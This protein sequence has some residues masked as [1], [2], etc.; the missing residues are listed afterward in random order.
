MQ[1]FLGNPESS[2]LSVEAHCHCLALAI[3][4]KTLDEN[5]FRTAQKTMDGEPPS[6]KIGDRI[7][8]KKITRQMG[9]QMKTQIQDCP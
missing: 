7:Y 1:E 5:C 4:K 9:P 2:L 3:A 8:F 6:F